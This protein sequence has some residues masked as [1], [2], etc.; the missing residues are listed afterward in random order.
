MT[1]YGANFGAIRF[2]ASSN[3]SSFL[4][5]DANPK[6]FA[7]QLSSP[8]IHLHSNSCYMIGRLEYLIHNLNASSN[9]SIALLVFDKPNFLVKSDQNSF[10][11]C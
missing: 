3:A 5:S 9:A 8:P 6:I 2:E 4:P 11:K 10:C 1:K 7:K